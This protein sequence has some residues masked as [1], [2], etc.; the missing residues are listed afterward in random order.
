MCK[1]TKALL[2]TFGLLSCLSKWT[3][4]ADE[5]QPYE[6]SESVQDEIEIRISDIVNMENDELV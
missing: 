4:L 2:V 3:V 5:V 6:E 1:Y